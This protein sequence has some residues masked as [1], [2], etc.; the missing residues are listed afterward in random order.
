MRS[1]AAR[2]WGFA[3]LGVQA[4]DACGRRQHAV[5]IVADDLD[6]KPGN[7]IGVNRHIGDGF[8]SHAA[9]V[10]CLPGGSGE[11]FA[12]GLAMLV[13]ELGVGSLQ[14]PSELRGITLA[15]VDLV[16]LGMNLE[17]KAFSGRRL[18]AF[19]LDQDG[20]KPGVAGVFR[21]VGCCRGVLRPACLQLKVFLFSVGV[22][23]CPLGATTEAGWL[24][25]TDFSCG[26]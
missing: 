23:E 22:G 7:G 6:E 5:A 19:Q 9:S 16:A 8:A 12:E 24:C 3:T 17:K 10:V 15:G 21:Q 11:M 13:E 4:L 14:C 26:P 25:M 1:V 2:S 20:I 18:D